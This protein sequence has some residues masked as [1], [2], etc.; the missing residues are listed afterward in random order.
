MN[1]MDILKAAERRSRGNVDQI[2]DAVKKDFSVFTDAV[3]GLVADDPEIRQRCT[4]IVKNLTRKRPELLESFKNFLSPDLVVDKAAPK[5][6]PTKKTSTRAK[7]GG[8]VKARAPK[9]TKRVVAK[10]KAKPLKKSTSKS[11]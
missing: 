9:T 10:P 2:V 4:D 7:A 11:R 3:R 8:A 1:L 6:G 5:K